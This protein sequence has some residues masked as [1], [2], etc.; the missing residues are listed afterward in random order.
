[1]RLATFFILLFQCFT[2]S[3]SPLET[4]QIRIK[5]NGNFKDNRYFLC[6]PN[7]GC[8]SMKAAAAGKTYPIFHPIEIRGLFVTNMQTKQ[9]QALSTPLSCRVKADPGQSL[10]I[11]GN[12]S[13]AGTKTQVT[14]LR[15][16]LS[17]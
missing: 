11:T 9:V 13:Q 15:C 1:M 7:V 10:I 4:V 8:L 14:S 5:I 2:L 17:S 6:I 12:L 16:N 3:A